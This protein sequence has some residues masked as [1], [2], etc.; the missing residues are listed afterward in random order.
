MLGSFGVLIFRKD[1]MKMRERFELLS[2]KEIVKNLPLFGNASFHPGTIE[3]L[4]RFFGDNLESK[5]E[6][7][8]QKKYKLQ[9]LIK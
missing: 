6:D 7:K 1:F 9:A 8:D 4:D 2:N 3:Y 5:M